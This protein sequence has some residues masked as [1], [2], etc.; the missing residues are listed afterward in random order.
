MGYE[1]SAEVTQSSVDP[2]V[3]IFTCVPTL[4]AI[5]ATVLRPSATWPTEG[6]AGCIIKP[7]HM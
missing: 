1:F 5:G 4:R 6:G 3:Q 2:A 7:V